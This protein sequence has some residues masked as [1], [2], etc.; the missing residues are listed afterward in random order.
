MKTRPE[1]TDI[2]ISI[3]MEAGINQLQPSATIEVLLKRKEKETQSL[4]YQKKNKYKS[5]DST[6]N[7]YTVFKTKLL[8]VY[9]Q[10]NRVQYSSQNSCKINFKILH[11]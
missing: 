11:F 6:K 7:R 1:G 8:Q 4:H 5:R 9:I 10:N 2:S 3:V